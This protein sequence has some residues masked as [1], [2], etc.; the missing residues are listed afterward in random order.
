MSEKDE[1]TSTSFKAKYLGGHSLFPNPKDVHLEVSQKSIYVPEMKLKIPFDRLENAQLVKEE[2]KASSLV[3]VPWM[4]EK[5]FLML[6]FVDDKDYEESLFLD[7]E[8]SEEAY[9]TIHSAK[10]NCPE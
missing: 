8:N 6:T 3:L 2:K 1:S 10:T 5:K 7:V 4:K 9:T